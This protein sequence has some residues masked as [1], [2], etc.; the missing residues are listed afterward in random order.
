MPLTLVLHR[1]PSTGERMLQ[2][3]KHIVWFDTLFTTIP[4]L[5]TLCE[6]GIGAVGTVRTM[7]K[8]VR[9][10]GIRR[11]QLCYCLMEKTF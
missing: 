3:K 10:N 4:L 8:S 9:S 1:D 5:E 11:K 2:E 6:L 7:R